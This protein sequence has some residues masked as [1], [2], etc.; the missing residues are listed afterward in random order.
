[1]RTNHSPFVSAPAPRYRRRCGRFSPGPAD[2][3]SGRAAPGRSSDGSAA[4]GA[5]RAGERTPAHGVNFRSAGWTCYCQAL[6]PNMG[7][8]EFQHHVPQHQNVHGA[9]GEIS[10][11]FG[12]VNFWLQRKD[13]IGLTSLPSN[14]NFSGF[15]SL[16][17]NQRRQGI[18]KNKLAFYIGL[19]LDPCHIVCTTRSALRECVSIYHA[20]DT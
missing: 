11:D 19:G 7:N 15:S 2:P 4:R 5:S 18:K 6:R 8:G 1:M 13:Y 14:V 3:G 12:R 16:K 20:L 10:P 9:F 17:F